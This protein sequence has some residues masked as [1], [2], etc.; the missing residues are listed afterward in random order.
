MMICSM[1]FL[2]LAINPL[3]IDTVCIRSDYIEAPIMYSKKT[4]SGHTKKKG[5]FSR[6]LHFISYSEN[7]GFEQV[8]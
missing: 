1:F 3:E 4:N 8:R 6:I 2:C 7:Q 5:A